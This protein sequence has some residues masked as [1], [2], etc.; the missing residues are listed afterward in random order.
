MKSIRHALHK[1]TVTGGDEAKRLADLE[2]HATRAPQALQEY[3]AKQ[4]AA[5]AAISNLFAEL[6]A[7]YPDIGPL[8]PALSSL[9]NAPDVPWSAASGVARGEEMRMHVGVPADGIV[10][11]ARR[12]AA[13]VRERDALKAESDHY[14]EKVGKLQ[15][16]AVGTAGGSK[17]KQEA[18]AARLAENKTKLLAAMDAF[19]AKRASVGE[20]MARLDGDVVSLLTPTTVQ[21]LR[22]LAAYHTSC[23]ARIEQALAS[24]ADAVAASKRASGAAILASS[25]GASSAASLSTTAALGGAGGAAAPTV[26]QPMQPMQ[27]QPQPQPQAEPVTLP[28]GETAVLAA[29]LAGPGTGAGVAPPPATV[30]F[31]PV[32]IPQQVSAGTLAAANTAAAPASAS[33]AVGAAALSVPPA[34]ACA[35]TKS[36]PVKAVADYTAAQEGDLAFRKRDVF[37]ITDKRESLSH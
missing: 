2:A 22:S 1:V 35:R 8:A 24:V 14:Q 10:S 19:S 11:L 7:L 18:A 23:A 9:A 15:Q 33:Q 26:Q 20:S 4:S 32:S 17:A 31:A 13:D 36:A 5:D 16:D 3:A 6:S 37:L 28:Q 21:L 25:A 27:M 29:A 34:T 30:V 12:A